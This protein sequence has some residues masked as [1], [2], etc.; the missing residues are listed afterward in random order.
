MEGGALC[1]SF[2]PGAM[3]GSQ[4]NP[5]GKRNNQKGRFRGKYDLKDL[6]I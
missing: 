5:C 3:G 6:R 1:V 4:Q 2:A